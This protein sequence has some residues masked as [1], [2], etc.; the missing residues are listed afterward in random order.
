MMMTSTRRLS[1]NDVQPGEVIAEDV[2]SKGQLLVQRGTK[3]TDTLIRSLERRG[4]EEIE[5]GEIQADDE[6]DSD[7]ASR[8][9]DGAHRADTRVV[10]SN[11]NGPTIR[12]T[13]TLNRARIRLDAIFQPYAGDPVMSEIKNAGMA[14][15]EAQA[16]KMA[17]QPMGSQTKR[18]Y[19]GRGV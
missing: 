5:I 15:W 8:D 12:A 19:G 6:S 3:L 1:I 13:E 18:L 17:T 16:Q 4:I 9:R 7:T 10:D 2:K 11:E 14:F